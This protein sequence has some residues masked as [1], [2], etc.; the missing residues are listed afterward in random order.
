MAHPSPSSALREVRA[1][2]AQRN[3]ALA[4]L[5]IGV[6]LALV[7][8]F[9]TSQDLGWPGRIAYWLLV[10]A[11]TYAMGYLVHAVLIPR[12][13]PPLHRLAAQACA[14]IVTGLLVAGGILG[15]NGV[16]FGARPGWDDAALIVGMT[17]LISLLLTLLPGDTPSGESG[18]PPILDR[19]PLDKRG[20]LVALSVEDHY[21]RVRTTRGEE[22]ILMRLTDAI[23]ETGPAAG[24]RVHRS[25]WV[26]L[27]QVTAATRKG[28]GA[29]L[30]MALG[31]DIPVSR[32]HMPQV[33]EAGLLP[34]QG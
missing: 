27:D 7:G 22:M 6:L 32:S 8:P 20:P 24:L 31:G 26:A 33:K 21:V 14:G 9:G 28:D 2:L 18:P 16:L 25:H 15:L 29:L 30:S 10:P 17:V 11:A 4:L 13:S 23:R 5:G 19:L 1:H 3:V 34:R 12:L